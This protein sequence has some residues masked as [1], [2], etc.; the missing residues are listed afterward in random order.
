MNEN[1]VLNVDFFK[2]GNDF[3]LVEIFNLLIEN[4]LVKTK[5]NYSNNGEFLFLSVND[6]KQS[7]EILSEVIIDFESYKTQ[8]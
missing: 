7:R 6:N 5:D 4:K 8:E 3:E 2:E 1:K